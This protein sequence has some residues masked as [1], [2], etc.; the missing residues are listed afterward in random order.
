[1]VYPKNYKKGGF[2]IAFKGNGSKEDI[3]LLLAMEL[4]RLEH[5]FETEEFSNLSIY[6]HLK[7]DGKNQLLLKKDNEDDG[8]KEYKENK[9]NIKNTKKETINNDDRFEVITHKDINFSE[10]EFKYIKNEI[11]IERQI[12]ENQAQF[13]TENINYQE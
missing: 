9:I 10:I 11:D 3:I 5:L 12:E 8:F 6:F 7:K 13:K 1:M 2:K 4:N